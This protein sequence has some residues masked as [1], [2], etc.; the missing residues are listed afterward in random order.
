MRYV[1][2]KRST[3]QTYDKNC[4]QMQEHIAMYMGEGSGVVSKLPEGEFFVW[5]VCMASSGAG[6]MA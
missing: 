2:T 1:V 3:M 5:L 6:A 4:H